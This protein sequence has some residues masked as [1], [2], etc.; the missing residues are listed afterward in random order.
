MPEAPELKLMSKYINEISKNRNF[1]KIEKSSITKNIFDSIF[2]K[3]NIKAESRGK[4]FKLILSF[5]DSKKELY[6]S[7][8]MSG[9]WFF[10]KIEDIK[11]HSHLKFYT[12]DGYVLSF[13]D[14]R[15]FGKWKFKEDWDRT[16]SP[17][18]ALNYD[19]YY[20]YIENK[21]NDKYLKKPIYEVLMNQKYFNGIGNYLRAEILYRFDIDPF[22]PTNEIILNKDFIKE[23]IKTQEES[24]NIGGGEIK[25]FI[26]PNKK[27]NIKENVFKDWL[28][29]YEKKSKIK[30]GTGRTFWYDKK[31]KLEERFNLDQDIQKSTF[32]DRTIISSYTLHG[33]KII[34]SNLI[35]RIINSKYKISKLYNIIR[36][37]Y[38]NGKE[39]ISSEQLSVC[40]YKTVYIETNKDNIDMSF[41]IRI[42]W[43][44]DNIKDFTIGGRDTIPKIND[45]GYDDFN[46]LKK[47]I[48]NN[49]NLNK[50]IKDNLLE[51]L[52]NFH[53]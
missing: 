12:T 39:P 50:I 44:N 46:E 49:K 14:P 41:G 18:M 32:L 6:M 8:G 38:Y 45:N 37:P 27:S 10:S 3:F 15:R 21:I 42:Q 33:L 19:E 11:K 7:M 48:K 20:E 30:D 43:E 29:C 4:E 22:T 25:S 24:F 5:K 9:N 1:Y 35:E 53:K 13:V 40:E 2:D 17:D 36:K 23:C 51:N 52:I 28:Q 34:E 16:R 47:D 31:W 26:N